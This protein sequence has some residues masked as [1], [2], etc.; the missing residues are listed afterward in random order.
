METRLTKDQEKL[1][2]LLY[3]DYLEKRKS[4]KP[5]RESNYFGDSNDIR[6]KHLPDWTDDDASDICWD[7][8]RADILYCAPGDNLANEVSLTSN[9]ISMM[10]NRFKDGLM[11][12]IDVIS[13]LVP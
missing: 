7:L 9:A 5:I 2:C 13:K 11:E 12:V 6:N 10:E 3:K 8:C 4:G 1:L